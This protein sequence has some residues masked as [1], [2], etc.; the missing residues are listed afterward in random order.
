M[1]GR[2]IDWPASRANDRTR[3]FR[4]DARGPSRT[5]MMSAIRSVAV[6]ERYRLR[7]ST[8][9]NL[10]LA[11]SRCRDG[12]QIARRNNITDRDPGKRQHLLVRDGV[13]AVD[14]DIYHGLR[15]GSLRERAGHDERER[16]RDGGRRENSGPGAARGPTASHRGRS[17]PTARMRPPVS[18]SRYP[19]YVRAAVAS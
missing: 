16:E 14:P 19:V 18:A 8:A 9:S 6:S 1:I 17:G 13:V 3:G 12:I 7:T 11:S 15:Q 10:P 5:T 2:N 4:I